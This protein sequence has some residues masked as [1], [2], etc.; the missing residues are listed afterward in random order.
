MAEHEE[1]ELEGARLNGAK[2]D[3]STI[4]PPTQQFDP[5]AAG[6][7]WT[8]AKHEPRYVPPRIGLIAELRPR[9]T[10]AR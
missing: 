7:V 9:S 6:A 4:W 1:A 2:Y 3:A 5:A 8:D 10:T